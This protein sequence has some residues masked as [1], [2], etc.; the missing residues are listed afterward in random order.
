VRGWTTFAEALPELAERS[1]VKDLEEE[2]HRRPSTVRPRLA[3][4]LSGVAPKMADLLQPTKPAQVTWFGRSRVSRR[5]DK[6][7]N[8]ADGLLPFDPRELVD[9]T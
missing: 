8:V 5:F 3:Y 9:E 4:L 1:S 6:R 7:F 2:L